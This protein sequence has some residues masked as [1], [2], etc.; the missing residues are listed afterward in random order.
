MLPLE[1][2]WKILFLA[3][4]H[5][6]KRAGEQF[7]PQY[8]LSHCWAEPITSPQLSRALLTF[9]LSDFDGLERTSA[10][11]TSSS[12]NVVLTGWLP[13]KETDLRMAGCKDSDPV[14]ITG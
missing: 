13:Q 6:C 14:G 7:P 12:S 11:M 4:H 9:Q 10:L 2:G 5:R 3:E 1:S 8:L